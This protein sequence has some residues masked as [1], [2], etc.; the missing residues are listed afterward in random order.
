MAK[1]RTIDLPVDLTVSFIMDNL[2]V[3]PREDLLV[4]VNDPI[5][6]PFENYTQQVNASGMLHIQV[7]RDRAVSSTRLRCLPLLQRVRIW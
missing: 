4:V 5:Y 7:R 2:S 3:A 1:D 6:Y